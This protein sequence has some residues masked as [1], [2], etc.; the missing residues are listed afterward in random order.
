MSITIELPPGIEAAVLEEATRQGRTVADVVTERLL[1]LYVPEPPLIEPGSP[2]EAAAI[3]E[4]LEDVAAGRVHRFDPTA[5][6]K[7]HG[8]S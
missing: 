1:A 3:R 8:V 6:L 4:G 5:V 7:K 2:E